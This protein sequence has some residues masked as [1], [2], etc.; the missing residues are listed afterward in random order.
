MQS[1]ISSPKFITIAIA[2][3]ALI[4]V[5]LTIIQVQ[6][7]QNLKQEAS[8]DVSTLW[9]TDQS[10]SASCPEEGSGV[11]IKVKFSNT[12]P[13]ENSLAMDV[14]AK[15][16]QTGK[17]VDMG[18][19]RGGE[20]KTA[21]IDTSEKTLQDG[22]VKFL[23]TWSDG[24]DGIDSRTAGYNAVQECVK[25][26]QPEVPSPSPTTPPNEPTPTPT[27]CPTLGPVQNVRIECPNCP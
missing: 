18:T 9:L 25:P 23:L 10:A 19:I 3:I 6:N 12:E 5:P 15:D 11:E 20:T 24:H 16:Q 21:F 13:D 14:I 17:E 22:T 1:F 26:T 4:A 27:V 2:L 7:Q 8:D